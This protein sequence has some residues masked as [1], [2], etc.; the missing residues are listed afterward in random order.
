[1]QYALNPIHGGFSSFC[2]ITQYSDV[3]LDG[4]EGVDLVGFFP[5][6]GFAGASKVSVGGGG[7]VDR[8]TKVEAFDD[9]S[10]FGRED[11]GDHEAEF[12]FGDDASAEGIDHDR[13]GFCD[14]DGVGELDFA[15][16]GKASRDDVFG[17]VAGHISSG[18]VDFAGVFARECAATVTTHPAV[19]INDDLASGESAIAH[20]AAHNKAS[21]GVDVVEDFGGEQVSGDDLFDDFFDDAFA[22]LFVAD[23]GAVLGRDHDS[24]D[25]FGFAV[26]VTDGHLG[27]SVRAKEREGSVFANSGEAFGEAVGEVDGHGHE[28]IGFIASV[29][30]HHALIASALLFV[31]SRAFIDTLGDIGALFVHGDED[32]A[33]LV[34]K[35]FVGVIVADVFDGIACDLLEVECG[36]GGDLACDDDQSGVEEGFACNATTGIFFEAGIKDCIGDLVCHLVGV[37]FGDGF[38]SKQKILIHGL[39]ASILMLVRPEWQTLPLQASGTF[40]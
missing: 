21:C 31:E 26:F 10:G 6:E 28:D 35:A 39:F 5:R 25:F 13:D 34:I 27:L 37:A 33:C 15:A 8:A 20:R 30:E 38:G 29:T 12:F 3:G 17:D 40:A 4:F 36:F 9:A 22:D 23:V 16:C 7:A 2:S 19:G 14:A 1:M 24:G 18:A 11:L 32:S